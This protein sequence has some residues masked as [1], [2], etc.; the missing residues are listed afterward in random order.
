MEI[1]RGMKLTPVTGKRCPR[2]PATSFQDMHLGGT[3]C[4]VLQAGLV[5]IGQGAHA[6]PAWVAAGTARS[7]RTGGSRRTLRRH[8][9]YRKLRCQLSAVALG[10]LRLLIAIHQRFKPVVTVLADVLEN[11][12]RRTPSTWMA[13]PLAIPFKIKLWGLRKPKRQHFSHA[14]ACAA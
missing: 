3:A 6:G 10:T 8:R 4:S 11:R 5:E 7:T 9:K 12:H 13:F 2:S 14:A 1:A